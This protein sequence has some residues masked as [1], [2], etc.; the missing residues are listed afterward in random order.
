MNNVAEEQDSIEVTVVESI[1]Y[2]SLKLGKAIAIR[3]KAGVIVQ[4]SSIIVTISK[5]LI[6]RLLLLITSNQIWAK[7][8]SRRRNK[9]TIS[10]L[11]D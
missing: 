2:S 6:N 1:K 5:R 11:D 10:S 7:Y 3:I 4:I 9:W 8:L